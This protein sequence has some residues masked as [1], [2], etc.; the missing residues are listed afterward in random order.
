MLYP[1]LKSRTRGGGRGCG[2]QVEDCVEQKEV[3]G[4]EP[5]AALAVIRWRSHHSQRQAG[6]RLAKPTD[7]LHQV[8][9]PFVPFGVWFASIL[10]GNLYNGRPKMKLYRTIQEAITSVDNPQLFEYIDFLIQNSL[11]A[12]LFCINGLKECNITLN[13]R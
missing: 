8:K 5:K 2:W 7:V 11:H 3:G 12:N 6:W 1:H 13:Q 9:F 4:V 10:M